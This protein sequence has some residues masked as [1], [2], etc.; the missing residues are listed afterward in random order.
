MAEVHDEFLSTVFG[1]DV[2]TYDQVS[3]DDL[4]KAAQGTVQ[5]GPPTD[6]LLTATPEMV[7][8]YGKPVTSTVPEDPNLS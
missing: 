3:T 1:V 8:R 7:Y 2:S 4:V 6:G 5:P